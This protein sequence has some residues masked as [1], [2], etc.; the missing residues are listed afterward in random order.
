L[1]PQALRSARLR[2]R[3]LLLLAL[4]ALALSIG[5]RGGVGAPRAAGQSAGPGEVTPQTDASAPAHDVTMIGASPGEAADETWGMGLQD[6]AS[7][8]VRYTHE[9][10]WSLGPGL[11]DSGGQPLSGF[12]LDHPEGATYEFPSPLAGQMTTDGSGVLAGTVPVGSTGGVEPVLLVRNP[13]G[14]FQETAPLPSEGEAALGEGERLLGINR[15]PMVAALEEPGGQTGALVAPVDEAGE[16][17]EDRV[18][19]WDGGAKTWTSEPIEIPEESKGEF[20]VLAIGASSPENAWLLARLSSHYPTGS[21]ALFRRRLGKEGEATV[22]QP[23][24]PKPEGEPGEQLEVPLQPGGREKLFTV[25]SRYQSQVLTVTSEGVW[26]DGERSDVG[27]PTTMFFKPEGTGKGHVTGSWCEIPEGAPAGTETCE[28]EL[29]E[30]LP[31]ARVRSFAWAN[32]G[33]STGFGER[34]ITGFRDGVSLRLEGSEFKRVLALGGGPVYHSEDVGGTFGSAFSNPREGWLGQAE[35]PVHLTLEPVPS[36]LAAWPTSFRHALLALAPA[37]ATAVGSLS[38]E[39]LAV[40]DDGEVARYQPGK[41]WLPETLL[42]PGGRRETPRLR[43]V[44]WPR[45][46]R[47]YAVG[48]LGQMWLWRGETGLWEADPATP[49][50]FRGNLLG[51]AFD[52]EEPSIGYAVGESGVLLKYGK[53]WAQEPEEDIP[54]PARGASFTSIAFAGSEA[55]VAYR[56]LV[57]GTARYEGGLI[58]NAGTGWQLDSGAAAAMGTNAPWA[59]AGLA[60][61]GAAFTASGEGEGGHVYERQAAGAA[62]Q[63]TPTPFPGDIAPGSIALFREGGALRVLAASS[64]P[65]T[66]EVESEAAAPPGFPPTLIGPYPLA[67][68][69]EKGLL[70]Q[71]ATGWSDEEH[72]LNNIKELEGEYAIYDTVYRP[73]PVAAVMVDPTGS[74]GWAVG[75]VVDEENAQMDTADVWRYP[76][77]DGATPPGEGSAPIPAEAAGSGQATFAIGGGAQCAAPCADLAN[78]KIGPDVWLENALAEAHTAGARAFIYTGPRVT[79]GKTAGPPTLAIPYQQELDRYAQLLGASPIP[80][81]AA[82]SPTDL[83]LAHDE[84]DFKAAFDGFP[85]PFGTAAEDSGLA[86]AAPAG[87]PDAAYYAFNSSGTPEVRVIVLDDSGAVEHEQL[88]WLEAQLAAA[89][90]SGRPALVVGEADLPAEQEAHEVNAEEVADVLVEGHAAAYFFDSP[91]QDVRLPLHADGGQIESYGSGTLSFVSSTSQELSGFLGASGFLLVDVNAAGTVEVRLIPDIGELALEAEDGTLLRRSQAAS[92]EALARRPRSGNDAA[93]G[94]TTPLTDP[95]IP[96]PEKCVGSACAHG[97]EPEYNFSSSEPHVGNFVKEDLAAEPHGHEPEYESDGKPI[98]ESA[99]GKHSKSSLFCAF[100]PGT[101]IVTI[102]AGG[103]SSSLPVTVEAGSV[104]QPCGTVPAAASLAQQSAAAPVPPPP[105]PAP[106]AAAPASAPPPVPVPP[107]P[108]PVHPAA[109]APR[110]AIHP[111][112]PPFLLPP[113]GAS[114]LLAVVPVPVPTPARPTPPSG[115][116]AVTSPVE[117]PE[118]EEESEAAPES[119]SNEA[120]AYRAPEHEPVPVYVLGA[121]VL[122]AFAGASARR[123][124][125]R[126][127][128]ELRVAPATISAM[129]S[130]RQMTRRRGRPL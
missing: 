32:Q 96:I 122:A 83:D 79:T 63:E 126:R 14:S 62:W 125:G 70:R 88:A 128:R 99:D 82:A 90:A 38:S 77:E 30:A 25:P 95:Y 71:T 27:A 120:V 93:N 98:L 18:L 118:R 31:K 51:I 116:S 91:E 53:T 12:K 80:A 69:Q 94:S 114:A 123:R 75:G 9:G 8:L 130:E 41:G 89:R 45:P 104:R 56:K 21:V 4:G 68:N 102:S 10:G 100:N 103:K 60:D 37:P 101:T 36:R 20:T 127:N 86:E 73:D 54:Q 66:I 61:G 107:L 84:E 17:S 112:S 113:T 49:L 43:A 13:G 59:V 74:Q 65:E 92:F 76:A 34:V 108:A 44:A 106:V 58:V 1:S 47:A 24:A 52:A 23:V 85:K 2:R 22:W 40:G 42:G 3:T 110:P 117:A 11:L 55:I 109:A 129:R 7:V 39:V 46:S 72:E 19:H 33:L 81:F 16:G 87:N 35:L 26:L 50:N 111:P 78:A 28:H 67:S 115:T 29:P 57:P 5:L 124:P 119:V 97:L 48:D 6:G 15:A 105:A 64:V 121:I